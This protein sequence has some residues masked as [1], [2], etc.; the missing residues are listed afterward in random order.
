M[1]LRPSIL[2]GVVVVAARLLGEKT[3]IAERLCAHAKPPSEALSP[4]TRRLLRELAHLAR[5]YRMGERLA[6]VLRGHG[7]GRPVCGDTIGLTCRRILRAE[8]RV[9]AAQRLAERDR[10]AA[11]A[12]SQRGGTA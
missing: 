6:I 3:A 11:H 4:S 5:A 9:S 7:A 2:L 12:V 1:T 10:E 8:L